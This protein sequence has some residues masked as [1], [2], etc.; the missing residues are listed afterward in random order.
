MMELELDGVSR[1]EA[2]AL[3]VRG[4]LPDDCTHSGNEPSFSV[5]ELSAAGMSQ[6]DRLA[7]VFPS[8]ASF[9]QFALRYE[10]AQQVR[11]SHRALEEQGGQR[12][13]TCPP[14]SLETCIS[15]ALRPPLPPSSVRDNETLSQY[16]IG[17]PAKVKLLRRL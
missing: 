6:Q 1:A 5:L 11:T 14:G 17:S 4:Q 3:T 8:V 7:S 13:R 12:R 16:Q 2:G 15:P 9:C 10:T